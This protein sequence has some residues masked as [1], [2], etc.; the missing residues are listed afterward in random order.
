MHR[1]IKGGNVML[2]SNYNIKIIDFGEA[3]RINEIQLLQNNT[4]I[5]GDGGDFADED[6]I[7][8]KDSLHTA[9]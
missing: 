5:D 2:D 3:K 1:D 7:E 8:R 6:E 9:I 4:I